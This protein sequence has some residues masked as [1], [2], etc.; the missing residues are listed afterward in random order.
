MRGLIISALPWV[1][2]AV[3]IWMTVLAGNKHRHAWAIGLGN[4]MLWLVWIVASGT[5]G[6]IPMNL[7]LWMIYARNHL[8]WDHDARAPEPPISRLLV[9]DEVP[10][11]KQIDTIFVRHGAEPPHW[12]LRDELVT[13]LQWARYGLRLDRASRR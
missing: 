9:S 12:R 1:L 2:S 8:K 6:L 13:H 10:L 5:W 3:T 7:I 4:Q 11:W